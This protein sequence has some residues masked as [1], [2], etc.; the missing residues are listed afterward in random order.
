MKLIVK[1]TDTFMLFDPESGDLVSESRPSVVKESS[2]IA[3]R[4]SI[5]HLKLLG[6]VNDDATDSEFAKTWAETK[7]DEK[8]AIESFISEYPLPA[9]EGEEQKG[10]KGK[11]KGK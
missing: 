6:Q 4:M 10:G 1:T 8:L 5:G 3:N 2:F 9:V 7:D 11:G